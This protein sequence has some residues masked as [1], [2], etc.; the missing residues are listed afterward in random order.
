MVHDDIDCS[1]FILDETVCNSSTEQDFYLCF[2][3]WAKDDKDKDTSK[4]ESTG[5]TPNK[6]QCLLS[7]ENVLVKTCMVLNGVHLE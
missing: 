2:T 3:L 4:N 5:L 1:L 7:K 6:I